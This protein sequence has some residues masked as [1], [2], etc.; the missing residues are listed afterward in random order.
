MSRL[1]KN[2]GQTVAAILILN[3]I[4][5]TGG[6]TLTGG[7]FDEAF[8]ARWL[9]LFSIGFTVLVLLVAEIVPKV[10]GATQSEKVAAAVSPFLAGSI[11]ALRPLIAIADLVTRRLQRALPKAERVSLGDLA[12]LAQLARQES[13]IDHRQESIIVNT[14]RLT[15]LSARQVMIGRDRIA[16]LRLDADPETNRQVARVSLHTRY[17]V[18]STN[19][20]DTLT[21]YV[22]F[23]E[24]MN[25]PTAPAELRIRDFLRPLISVSPDMT[26]NDVLGLLTQRRS[27]IA[28][29][30]EEGHILG[31]LTL[32]DVLEEIVGD[33][34]DEFDWVSSE[35]VEFCPNAWRVGGAAR[36]EALARVVELPD[37]GSTGQLTIHEWLSQR[38]PHPP[39]PQTFYSHG[40]AKFYLHKV[41]R[42]QI[43]EVI[44]EGKPRST[45]STEAVTRRD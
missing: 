26:A 30:R 10:I 41:R 28:V 31:L 34:E 35:V 2:L 17:P 8:G 11:Q 24:I 37:L 5:N 36:M 33:L 45:E 13:I 6:A 1:K 38:L 14:A 39:R 32:E 27:H 7:A 15:T 18:A 22:N 4:A 23:K 43:V 20:L 42:T 3:T 29:V 16:F 40:N 44:V 25:S 12:S 21:G 9:W 19:D